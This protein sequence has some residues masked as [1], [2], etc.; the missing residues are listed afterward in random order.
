LL[1]FL[2]YSSTWSSPSFRYTNIFFFLTVCVW[3][4]DIVRIFMAP[5]F[6]FFFFLF[7][8]Y[9]WP[10]RRADNTMS[11]FKKIPKSI[12]SPR[13]QSCAPPTTFYCITHTKKGREDRKKILDFCFLRSELPIG[14]QDFF[15][16]FELLLFFVCCCP[17]HFVFFVF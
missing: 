11:L 14:S 7:L 13:G 2:T 12:Y 3:C 10:Y 1:F 4:E 6:H 9:M 16:S 17:F 8:L 5:S 15:F